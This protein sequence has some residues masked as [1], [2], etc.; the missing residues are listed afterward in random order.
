M[1]LKKF[2]KQ[3]QF[4]LHLLIL[5]KHVISFVLQALNC[6]DLNKVKGANKKQ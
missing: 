4:T 1:K 2:D 3:Y 6:L 5:L